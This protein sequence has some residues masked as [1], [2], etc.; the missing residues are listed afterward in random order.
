MKF[1]ELKSIGHNIADSLAS[2]CGFL[3]G[4]YPIDIFGEASN[5]PEGYV[6][7]DFLAATTEGGHPSKSLAQA[8]TLY[9]HALKDLCDRHKVELS[10][11]KTL[12][13]RFGIDRVYGRHFTVTVEDQG[14]RQSVDSYLGVPGRRIRICIVIEGN[15][16]PFPP[17][18]SSLAYPIQEDWRARVAE[19]EGV[20][21][22]GA[23]ERV[24]L[25]RHWA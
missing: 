6:T 15:V 20:H 8:I 1:G 25:R 3:I 12:K 2:G 17:E 13:A 5:T 18:P 10:S 4:Y 21:S 23:S 24:D 22:L 11:F 9:S 19:R 14:G 16:K 7:V